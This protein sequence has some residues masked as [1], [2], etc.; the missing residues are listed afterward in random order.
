[1]IKAYL[2]RA[3]FWLIIVQSSRA[4]ILENWTVQSMRR[5]KKKNRT[6]IREAN[7]LSRRKKRQRPKRMKRIMTN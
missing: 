2:T 3:S 6:S 5:P 7:Q 1:M 4:L